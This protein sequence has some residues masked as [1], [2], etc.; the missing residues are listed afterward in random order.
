MRRKRASITEVARQAGVSIATVSRV[1]NRGAGVSDDMA[2]HVAE[3]IRQMAYQPLAEH[4]R[5]GP[6]TKRP[7]GRAQRTPSLELI[8]MFRLGLGWIEEQAP[9]FSRAFDG[10]E[11]AV[12][13]AGFSLTVRQIAH[14]GARLPASDP[15]TVAR[16]YFGSGDLAEQIPMPSDGLPAIWVMGNP[17]AGFTGDVVL[18]DHFAT[19]TL[20]ARTIMAA[21]HTCCAF[22]GHQTMP[23]SI[24]LSARAEGFRTYVEQHGGRAVIVS[25]AALIR[26]TATSNA[27][28]PARVDAGLAEIL[29]HDPR[30]TAL[31]LQ[32]DLMAPTVYASLQRAGVVPQ[33]DLMVVSCNND[34]RYLDDLQPPPPVIDVQAEALGELAV[35][36]LRWRLAHPR[37]PAIRTLVSPR[38]A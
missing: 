30:P 11:A 12:E 19:G 4:R 23:S 6:K 15:L 1:I 16:L 32:S 8:V 7:A 9:V 25:D 20:A 13:Q 18:P 29:R 14:G 10:I 37:A 33:Q 22:F 35:D 3:I 5:P 36:L 34:R 28:D 17:A 24:P 26:T 38:L 21:G 2:R 31:F 27:V